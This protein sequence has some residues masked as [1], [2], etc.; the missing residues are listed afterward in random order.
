M[1]KTLRIILD[2]LIILNLLFIWGNSMLAP[3]SSNAL[4]SGVMAKIVDFLDL[5][6]LPGYSEEIFHAVVRKA[7]HAF[8]FM[9]L[10]AMLTLRLKKDKPMYSAAFALCVCVAAIDE[11]IQMFTGRTSALKDVLIDSSGA[12][13]GVIIICVILHIL[14]KHKRQRKA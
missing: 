12:A 1:S 3:S 7:A 8:E 4:S 9:C 11:F 14:S 2:I 13:V 10:G 6:S 5:D